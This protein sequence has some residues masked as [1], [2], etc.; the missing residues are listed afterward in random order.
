MFKG[1]Q[2]FEASLCLLR[3]VPWPWNAQ[4]WCWH[5]LTSFSNDHQ[6]PQDTIHKSSDSE[7]MV[8]NFDSMMFYGSI[9]RHFK[10][11]ISVAE[12]MSITT[13]T[14]DRFYLGFWAVLL[15]FFFYDSTKLSQQ[16][17]SFLCDVPGPAVLGECRAGDDEYLHNAY[18]WLHMHICRYMSIYVDIHIYIYIIYTYVYWWIKHLHCE[19]VLSPVTLTCKLFFGSH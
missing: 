15:L 7:R 1:W 11:Q 14:F 4:R 17:G 10:I 6:D 8:Q 5:H 18:I 16:D 19:L 12:S 2:L 3:M 9:S 13:T